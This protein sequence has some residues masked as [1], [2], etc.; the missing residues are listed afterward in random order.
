MCYDDFVCMFI[1]GRIW[2][3]GEC[4]DPCVIVYDLYL[5]LCV[6]GERLPFSHYAAR[7]FLGFWM[8]W[9]ALNYGQLLRQLYC[10]W[11]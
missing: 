6:F 11:F 5:R 1:P 7:F 10:K 4:G 8:V 9:G 3:Y 2:L